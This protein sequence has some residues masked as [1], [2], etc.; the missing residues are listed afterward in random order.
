MRVMDAWTRGS[1]VVA[2]VATAATWAAAQPPDAGS[3]WPSYGGTN[4]SQKYSPLDQISGA[5]MSDRPTLK[6]WPPGSVQGFDVRTGDLKWVFHTIPQAGEFGEHTWD[7]GSNLYTGNANVWSTLSGD[8]E[9][10]HVY[11]ATTA[12]TNDYWA[13]SVGSRCRRDRWAR[14]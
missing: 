4:W 10:G 3:E 8:E 9:L 2:M 5:A 13:C 11:L 14:R 7:D 6:E 12:P 1:L